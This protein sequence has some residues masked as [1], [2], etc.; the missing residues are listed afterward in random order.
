MMPMRPQGIFSYRRAGPVFA[1]GEGGAGGR[2]G[3]AGAKL[4]D[5]AAKMPPMTNMAEQ[6][7]LTF[8]VFDDA[9]SLWRAMDALLHDGLRPAQ[10]CLFADAESMPRLDVVGPGE[11]GLAFSEGWLPPLRSWPFETAGRAIAGTEGPL[12]D[13]LTAVCDDDTKGASTAVAPGHRMDIGDYVVQGAITLVVR[14]N[15]PAQQSLTA[16]TLLGHSSHR[17]RT[18]EFALP[19]AKKQ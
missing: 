16:R 2:I 7:R 3:R 12:F 13:A 18:F 14:S 9:P 6:Y 8:A 10:L 19:A 11:S 15:G 5:A 4:S 17:V 1:L